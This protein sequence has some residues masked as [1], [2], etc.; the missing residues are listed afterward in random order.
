[1]EKPPPCHAYESMAYTGPEVGR[2]GQGP[3]VVP[4]PCSL[5]SRSCLHLR[6]LFSADPAWRGE[7][8]PRLGPTPVLSSQQIMPGEGRMLDQGWFHLRALF[9][10][11]PAW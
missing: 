4:P 10:A 5:L 11:D 3:G 7:M 9:S 8:F 1:M 2:L 6:A